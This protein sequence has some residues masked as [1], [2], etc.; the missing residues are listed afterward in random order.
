MVESAFGDET[1]DDILDNVELASE[2]AYTAVGTYDHA[3]LVTM[4]VKLSELTGTPVNELV[5]AFG[6]HLAGVFASKYASFFE[7]VD[8]TLAF[9]RKI[10]DHIHVEVKK[11]YPDAELPK[12]TFDDS[13]DSQFVLH[14]QSQRGFADLA[15]GL[16]EAS[17]KYYG[18]TFDIQREDLS[19]GQNTDVRFILTRVDG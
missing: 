13:S 7:E 3:E 6:H 9:L 17:A 8:S 1:L 14:Y 4:V 15:H 18:E 12:F 16:I 5:R 11:L 19:Q 10:D 2:G